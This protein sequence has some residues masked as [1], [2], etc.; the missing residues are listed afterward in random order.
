MNS[1]NELEYEVESYGKSHRGKSSTTLWVKLVESARKYD[2]HGC[3]G[4]LIGDL[5]D[6]ARRLLSTLED[7][8]MYEIWEQTENGM[9]CIDED[10]LLVDRA[11]M[12][13]D[14]LLD[15]EWDMVQRVCDE[16]APRRNRSWRKKRAP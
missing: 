2:E 12:E 3:D 10:D 7:A 1:L 14:I 4:I 16:V 9:I 5:V 13:H 8:T 15:V 6:H 11:T